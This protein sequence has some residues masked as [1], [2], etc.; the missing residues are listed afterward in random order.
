M[1]MARTLLIALA[2]LGFVACSSNE[3]PAPTE[4]VQAEQPAVV[5]DAPGTAGE[6]AQAPQAAPAPE[7]KST[8]K[9]IVETQSSGSLFVSP[10]LLNVRSGP[11]MNFKVARTIPHNEKVNVIGTENLI[12]VKIGEGEYVSSKYLT[13]KPTD[14][15]IDPAVSAPAEKTVE[16]AAQPAAQP[17]AQPQ[18]PQTNP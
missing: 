12:W 3:P 4:P 16:P 8:K 13:E 17:E 2:F 11:G 18:Q 5:P 6:T 9:E 10:S 7:A 1:I 15:A 14:K